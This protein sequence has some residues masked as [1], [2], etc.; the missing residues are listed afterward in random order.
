MFTEEEIQ[1]IKTFLW[2][3]PE[4]SK[5]Y[6]GADSLIYK[7]TKAEVWARYSVVLVV[8]LAQKHGCKV[9]SFSEKER[10]FDQNLKKPIMRLNTEVQKVVETWQALEEVIELFDPEVHL[11]INSDPL[12]ASNLV[13]KQAL[14][15]V[16]GVTGIDAKI[17]PESMV[18]S[19]CAD[20]LVKYGTFHRPSTIEH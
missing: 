6:L 10:V 7:K 3:A 17:K 13:V 1:E 19:H 20:H 8:H 5:V 9:F 15:Y 11:D 18:A 2:N 14:G 4:N 16:K 12:Y